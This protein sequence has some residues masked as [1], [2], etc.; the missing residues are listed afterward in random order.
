MQ[1][2]KQSVAPARPARPAPGQATESSKSGLGQSMQE[3]VGQ[4]DASGE[5]EEEEE[6][7]EKEQDVL[8]QGRGWEAGITGTHIDE[9]DDFEATYAAIL[10]A[11]AGNNSSSSS[12]SGNAVKPQL[13]TPVKPVKPVKPSACHCACLFTL[14][15]RR[16][17][18]Q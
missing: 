7:E 6:E 1:K 12:S 13:A 9:M 10:A 16:S 5:E 11:Q 4:Q 17:H 8:V 18:I 3:V 2:Q 15:K 14:Q